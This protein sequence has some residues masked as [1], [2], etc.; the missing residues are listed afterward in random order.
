M[1]SI[2]H[3]V[4]DVIGDRRKVQDCKEQFCIGNIGKT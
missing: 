1:L 4:V 2:E 3:P